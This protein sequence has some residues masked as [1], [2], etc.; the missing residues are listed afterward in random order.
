MFA[1]L[2]LATGLRI[3]V[4]SAGT[5]GHVPVVKESSHASCR[6]ALTTATLITDR[7]VYG[8]RCR[9]QALVGLRR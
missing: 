9:C 2:L 6:R 5:A 4:H 1:A 8:E 3:V 7:T